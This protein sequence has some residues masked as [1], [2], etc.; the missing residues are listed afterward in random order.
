[1]ALDAESGS[2]S[3]T[4][5]MR[6]QHLEAKP[7]QNLIIRIPPDLAARLDQAAETTNATKSALVRALLRANLPEVANG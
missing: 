3:T 6:L 2:P 4:P 1:M 7:T 5:A